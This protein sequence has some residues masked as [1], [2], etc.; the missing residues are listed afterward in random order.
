MRSGLKEFYR[1]QLLNAPTRPISIY[2]MAT[3]II[4][5][6]SLGSAAAFEI[7]LQ[8]DPNSEDNLAGYKLYYGTAS[9][10]YNMVVDVGKSESVSI[11]GLDANRP[12]FFA[13]SAYDTSRKESGYSDEITHTIA[14]I[15][16]DGLPDV[17]EHKYSLSVGSNDASGDPDKDG[18]TNQQEFVN[19]TNPTD[20]VAGLDSVSLALMQ[21]ILLI[22][23]D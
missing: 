23:N 18:Q 4:V 7:V 14:D 20:L 2:I 3:L 5:M 16:N 12:Y 10:T 21:T 13:V 1:H 19:G 17:W 15:D 11:A 8:W 9:R 22:L 6:T